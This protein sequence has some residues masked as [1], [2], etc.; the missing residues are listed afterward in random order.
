[1]PSILGDERSIKDWHQKQDEKTDF[2][3]VSFKGDRSEGWCKDVL[4][5]LQGPVMFIYCGR[6]VPDLVHGWKVRSRE[7]Y[8]DK[9]F[10][11]C[12]ME[13]VDSAEIIKNNPNIPYASMSV[14]WYL[15]D[16]SNAFTEIHDR[17][18]LE[19]GKHQK[20]FLKKRRVIG[21]P[22]SERKKGT[23]GELLE[24]LYNLCPDLDDYI[25][26]YYLLVGIEG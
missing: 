2:E 15:K 16:I 22:V 8:T 13:S 24:G 1:V 14:S 18:G 7:H 23:S 17:M 3:G 9:N 5:K 12:F 25:S 19:L 6:P 20:L 4:A 26:R 21:G 11:D 10:V